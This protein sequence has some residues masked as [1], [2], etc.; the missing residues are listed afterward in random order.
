MSDVVPCTVTHHGVPIGTVDLEVLGTQGLGTLTPLPAYKS[1]RA[2]I[3]LAGALGREAR[4]ELLT[5]QA[6]AVPSHPLIAKAALAFELVDQRGAALPTDVVRLVELQTRPGVTV[7]A[8]LRTDAAGKVAFMVPPLVAPGD[9]IS[10]HRIDESV[11]LH[12]A[13]VS[14]AKS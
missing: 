10:L 11:N 14:R 3:L 6:D 13:K 7:L 9:A 2:W 8:D 1:V 5:R 12:D 4:V